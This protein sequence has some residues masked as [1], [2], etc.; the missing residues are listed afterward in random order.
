[1]NTDRTVDGVLFRYLLGTIAPKVRAD[2]EK[3]LFSNDRI[4]WEQMCLAEDELIDAYVSE[5]LDHEQRQRF[6]QVFLTTADRRDKLT[7]ARALKAYSQR[8]RGSRARAGGRLSVPSWAAAAAAVLVVVLPALTWQ[9]ARPATAGGEMSA[10]LSSGLVR[11]VD[12]EL[13]RLR[14]PPDAKL[15]RL[16]LEVDA[17]TYPTYRA[18][19]HLASGEEVWAQNGLHSIAIGDRQAVE[20][21]L[22]A[23]LL[24]EGDFYVRLFGMSPPNDP[25]RLDRYD[26]RVLREHR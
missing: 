22:P 16:R 5:D 12:R 11:S 2:V 1:M 9:I 21:T 20:L 19:M 6:E 23:E 25:A 7:F 8:E 15:V 10:W 14:V 24:P 26:F 13:E 3:R 4:F 17:T 18:T